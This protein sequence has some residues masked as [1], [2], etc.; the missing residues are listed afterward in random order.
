MVQNNVKSIISFCRSLSLYIFLFS[1]TSTDVVRY[2]CFDGLATLAIGLDNG[3]GASGISITLISK[4]QWE[5]FGRTPVSRG[6]LI[7]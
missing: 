3:L 2:C 6:L 1:I 5:G 4:D 7:Q